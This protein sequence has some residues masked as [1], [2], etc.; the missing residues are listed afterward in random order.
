MSAH[1]D[2][3]KL[4]GTMVQAQA[5]MQP[6]SSLLPRAPEGLRQPYHTH[7]CVAPVYTCSRHTS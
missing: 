5:S 3:G 6:C 7:A 1:A 2:L 4:Y